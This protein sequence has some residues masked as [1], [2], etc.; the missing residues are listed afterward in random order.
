MRVGHKH[1]C[2]FVCANMCGSQC[3]AVFFC[4]LTKSHS[5][6]FTN[7]QLRTIYWGK[8][9]LAQRDAENTQLTLLLS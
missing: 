5:L 6:D 4:F 1:M 7:K 8:S 9:L 3:F 2:I